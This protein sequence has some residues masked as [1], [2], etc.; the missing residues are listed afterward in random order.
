MDGNDRSNIAENLGSDTI[1]VD[2]AASVSISV[3][4]C[5]DYGDSTSYPCVV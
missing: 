4:R 5:I 1:M 2:N 3:V